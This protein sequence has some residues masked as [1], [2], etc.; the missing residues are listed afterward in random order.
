MSRD[1][2]ILHKLDAIIRKISAKMK[3]NKFTRLL[4]SILS[5]VGLIRLKKEL[6]GFLFGLWYQKNPTEKMKEEKQFVSEHAQELKM[7]YDSLEDDRSRFVFENILKYRVT[8]NWTYLRRSKAK[9]NENTQYFVPEFHFSDHEII[10][11]CGAYT[12]DTVER[13]YKNIPGCRVIALEPE[14]KNFESLQNLKL[15]GLKVIKAGVWS[16]DTTLSFSDEGGGTTGGAISA[17]GNTKIEVKALDHLP[18]CQSA[19]YVK[20]DIE[21]AEMEALKGAEKII[22]KGKP[23]LAICIYHRPQDFFEI[24]FYIKKLNPDYKLFIHHHSYHYHHSYGPC[25]T[26]LYA[27]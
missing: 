22:K 16:E 21:G 24:P 11:D 1:D 14:E 12:G 5:G 17:S 7:V 4:Y 9:D 13:F 20:M 27:V 18:E 19:T 26:V 10:V 8:R 3:E 15:E 25:E 23:K 2:S 6:F